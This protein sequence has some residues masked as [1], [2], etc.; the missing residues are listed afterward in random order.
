[1]MSNHDYSSFRRPSY[2][3]GYNKGGGHSHGGYQPYPK[4]PPMQEETIRTASLEVERKTY[5]LTLSENPRGRL[6]RIVEGTQGRRNCI[7]IPATGLEDFQKAY[8]Q[9]LATARELPPK[10]NPL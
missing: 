2:N 7:I 6:L 10:D 8:E 9:L 4:P 3:Q 1:M 5:T